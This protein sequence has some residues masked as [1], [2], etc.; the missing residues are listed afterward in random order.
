MERECFELNFLKS[1]TRV[2]KQVMWDEILKFLNHPF[3]RL[4]SKFFNCFHTVIVFFFFFM[5]RRQSFQLFFFFLSEKMRSWAFQDTLFKC[6]PIYSFMFKVTL[7]ATEKSPCTSTRGKK[8]SNLMK[9]P[10]DSSS[11]DLL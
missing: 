5:K 2:K 8:S 7:T 1:K 10:K 11:R 9:T 3:N 4:V 6:V